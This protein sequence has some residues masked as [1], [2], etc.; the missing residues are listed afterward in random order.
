MA[1]V[2][3]SEGLLDRLISWAGVVALVLHDVTGWD[4]PYQFAWHCRA[5]LERRYEDART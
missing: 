3:T 4:R 5:V 1:D 2:K